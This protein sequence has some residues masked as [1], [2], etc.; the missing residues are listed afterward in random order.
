LLGLLTAVNEVTVSGGD[1]LALIK[2]TV[3]SSV[4]ERRRCSR[5]GRRKQAE[6]SEHSNINTHRSS[7]RRVGLDLALLYTKNS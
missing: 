7:M 6:L 1:L 4:R 5:K 2:L 3:I